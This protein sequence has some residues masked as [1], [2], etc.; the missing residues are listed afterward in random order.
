MQLTLGPV[1][2]NWQPD[3]WRDFYFLIADEAPVDTVVI[4]EVVCSKRSPFTAEHVPA[5]IER[6]VGAGKTV[7]LATLALVSLP[8]ERRQIAELAA[9]ED[10]LVEANDLSCVGALAGRPFAVGPFVNVY[11]EAT[12][13]FLAA[14]GAKRISLPPELPLSSVAVIAAAAPEVMIEV[15]A[16]GR[17]PLAISGRCYHARLHKLSRDN[18]QFVCERDPDGLAVE[19]MDGEGFLSVNGVQTL[20]HACVSL[21]GEASDLVA[22]GVGSLRLSPQQCDMSAVARIFRDVLDGRTD[23]LDGQ[24]KLKAIYPG[25]PFANGFIRGAPGAL[26]VS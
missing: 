20:S 11:N 22:A 24:Q 6:L 23:G 9:S 19:T 7:I 4:G 5:V 13:G 1:L 8:R 14:R 18:C 10:F 2:F 16:F 3:R 26:F 25:A 12:A 17:A 15:F 21:L